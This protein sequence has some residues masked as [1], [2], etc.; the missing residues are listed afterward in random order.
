MMM[1][2]GRLFATRCF[3]LTFLLIL[4]ACG[5]K[6]GVPR[7]NSFPVP[8]YAD[9]TVM[10]SEQKLT[11]LKEAM[12]FW[13]QKSGKKLF[14]FR[15]AYLSKSAPFKGSNEHPDQVVANVLFFQ[16]PWPHPANVIGETVVSF[17]GSE[18]QNAMIRI[19]GEAPFCE[20]DCI[21][22]FAR[23]SQ[24]KNFAHELGHFLGLEHV[25]DVTDVMNPVIQPGGSLTR[26]SV[27]LEA[28][29]K[30]TE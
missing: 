16:S 4:S 6:N 7:W 20:G 9:S 18:I 23:S 27:N 3:T 12:N 13:E 14:D 8:L 2:Q 19:N 28:L 22:D 11:D 29:T 30:V 26:V 17:S 24:K 10:S 1:C 21:G 15:G 25:Q 5:Q